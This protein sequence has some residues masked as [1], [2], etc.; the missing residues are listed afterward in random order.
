MKPEN[1]NKTSP[2]K[3]TFN[4]VKSHSLE[5]KVTDSRENSSNCNVQNWA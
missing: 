4:A 2:S 3:K 1:K 5:R